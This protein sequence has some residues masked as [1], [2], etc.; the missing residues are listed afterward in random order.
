[1]ARIGCICEAFLVL[2]VA[3]SVTLIVTTAC[4]GA[5]TLVTVMVWTFLQAHPI[6]PLGAL[7]SIATV[8]LLLPHIRRHL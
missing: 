1:M 8:V 5:L 7:Q 3:V 2:F 4:I 6:T